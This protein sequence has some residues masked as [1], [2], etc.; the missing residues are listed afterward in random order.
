MATEVLAARDGRVTIEDKFGRKY[1]V[2]ETDAVPYGTFRAHRRSAADK[3]DEE[4]RPVKLSPAKNKKGGDARN[5]AGAIIAMHPRETKREPL[6]Q[7]DVDETLTFEEACMMLGEM[8]GVVLS[9][10]VK[11]ELRENLKS[12]RRDDVAA[13]GRELVENLKDA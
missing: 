6:D 5:K 9:D 10:E 3:L 13:F 2:T 4:T 8:L 1:T 7:L 12:L 11:D